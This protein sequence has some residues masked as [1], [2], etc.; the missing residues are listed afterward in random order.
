MEILALIRANRRPAISHT[1]TPILIDPKDPSAGT[2]LA[3]GA[4][5]IVSPMSI[6]YQW[7]TEIDYHTPALRY[8]MYE[9]VDKMGAE[10]AET[11][12]QYDVILTTYDVLRKE[13]HM[14]R[15]DN[16]RSRRFERKMKRKTTPL[17]EIEWWRVCMDG[18]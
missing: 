7:A 17:I 11:L 5:L 14:A 18:R 16:M 15:G 6:V 10:T 8:F 1:V 4:T 2:V 9:G 13:L 3:S 12:A